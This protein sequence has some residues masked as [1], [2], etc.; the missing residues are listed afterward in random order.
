MRDTE[1]ARQI[2]I[3]NHWTAPD[4]VKTVSVKVGGENHVTLPAL[5]ITA[6][7]CAGR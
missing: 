5:S 4:R 6:F 2:D 7:E 1:D 3:A